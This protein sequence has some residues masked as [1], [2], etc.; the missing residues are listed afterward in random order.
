[1]IVSLPLLVLVFCIARSRSWRLHPVRW[2]GLLA[3][4]LILMIGGLVVSTKIGGGGD[5]H[6]MDAYLVLLGLIG[7]YFM[8]G[9]IAR[10]AVAVAEFATPPWPALAIVLIVP[11][12]F[13]FLRV[14]PPFTYDKAKAASDLSAV[15][16]GVQ[17][18]G[19]SGPVVFIYERQ[20]LTFGMIP[21]VALVPDYEV[22]SLMEM[23]LSGNEAYLTQLYKDLESHRF[24]AIVAH[25][26]N[27]GVE[28]GDFI[29]ESDVWNRLVAQPMLCQYKPALTFSYS[30]VQILVPRSR[31]CL[32]FPPTVR[33]P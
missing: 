16:V 12:A 25:P 21:D 3:M 28:T 20:L 8:S 31:P 29:E 10:E 15:R 33:A 11:V 19:K 18:Y 6:N 23:A 13:S 32:E 30:H 2:I 4:L 26:Q 7:V 27:L 9:Q 14:G 24:A 1:V 22:V 17:T 5:L